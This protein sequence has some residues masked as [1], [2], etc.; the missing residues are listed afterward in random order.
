MS[1]TSSALSVM[2][3]IANYF[4]IA[5]TSYVVVAFL[6]G[7]FAFRALRTIVGEKFSDRRVFLTP[8]LYSILVLLSFISSNFT[9]QLFASITAA[10][11]VGFGLKLSRKVEVYQRYHTLYFRKSL[12]VTFLWSMFFSI[13]VLTYLYYPKFYLQTLFTVLLTLMTGVI[14]G[15][16]L[17]IYYRVKKYGSLAA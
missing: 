15:E 13:K 2:F 7:L 5:V 1:I 3:Q 11:G 12:M 4:G 10:I 16:A 6:F 14:V 17:R 9:Q 8:V